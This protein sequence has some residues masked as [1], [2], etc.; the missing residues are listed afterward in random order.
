MRTGS[1]QP[2]R[3]I[4]G[5]DQFL[6]LAYSRRLSRRL[7]LDLK[8]T[9]GSVSLANGAFS[10]LPLTNTDLFAIPPNELF[11]IRT[12]FA[13]S[14]VDLTWQKTARLS[15]ESAAR[16]SWCAGRRSLW[17]GWTATTRTPTPLTA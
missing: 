17:R 13:Q 10:Y 8:E 12:N 7:I 14:R 6:N 3:S 2:T 11:D 5:L 4:H 16:A 1:I 15:F 9:A